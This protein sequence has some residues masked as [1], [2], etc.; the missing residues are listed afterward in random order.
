MPT[1]QENITAL[2]QRFPKEGLFAEKEWNLA[3]EPFFIDAACAGYLE[4]LG[5][6]LFKFLRAANLLYHQSRRGKQ[7]A[8]IA[9]Y[10]DAGKPEALKGLWPAARGDLP[11][12]IRPDIILTPEGL[13]L[14]EIDAV[15]GG[16][17]LTGWLNQAY[18][19]LGFDVIGGK[20]GMVDGFRSILP[21]GVIAVS[22]E[23]AT[24]RP[25][26]QWLA[27]ELN[28]QY[29]PHWRVEQAETLDFSI[30]QSVYRFFE[31]FDLPN[32]PSQASLLSAA[33]AGTLQITAPL[34][35]YLEEKLWFGLFWEKSLERFWER[36]LSR[37]H[38]QRL[39]AVIPKTWVIDPAPVPHHAVIPWL[40]IQN[41]KEL[42]AFSQKERDY[43]LKVSGF[44]ERA[45]GS[46]GV[47]V[48]TDLPQAEWARLIDEAVQ[49]FP[50]Q[51]FIL[52]RFHRGKLFEQGL[53]QPQTDRFSTFRGRV[54]LCPYY[55]VA[56]ECDI[57]LGGILATIVPADKK[58]VHGMRDAVIVP[59][60]VRA[61]R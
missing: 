52:Q 17:G 37:R 60:A 42:S 40:G 21:K 43:V 16:I 25:E 13:V 12:V 50:R 4:R 47:Y 23:A 57:R 8:W 9:E 39:R 5:H 48:G 29:G 51:P 14:S 28:R 61:E 58:L 26:M 7:P 19:D 56:S 45:W 49:S 59:V 30:P 10:L 33:R 44:S 34:K 24:Y 38:F 53:Y 18:A 32:L 27:G 54:R 22:K 55:F 41:W 11:K 1:D 2:Q 36:E 6:W 35:P 15:P 3:P 46:R 31:L 20:N